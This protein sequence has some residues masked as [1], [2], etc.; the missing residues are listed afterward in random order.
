MYLLLWLIGDGVVEQS[1]VRV[2]QKIN[3]HDL[4][5]QVTTD[6]F[7]P[8]VNINSQKM[9]KNCKCLLTINNSA[10]RS[11]RLLIMLSSLSVK[12]RNVEDHHQ[13]AGQLPRQE[14]N[15]GAGLGLHPAEC[16]LDALMWGQ[17][18]DVSH[19]SVSQGAVRRIESRTFP[20]TRK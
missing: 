2:K 10:L 19:S 1:C 8:T 16:E 17:S 5:K 4:Q 14:L 11:H 12:R 9:D 7:C 15:H 6:K 20:S 18:W 3:K 13:N